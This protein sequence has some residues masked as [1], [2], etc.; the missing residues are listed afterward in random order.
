MD[1]SILDQFKRMAGELNITDF[2]DGPT[3]SDGENASD[4]GSEP[5]EE[6][7]ESSGR[8]SPDEL[9]GM[10]D[11][12]DNELPEE[13]RQLIMSGRMEMER[14]SHRFD[15]M[16]VL[17]RR[18]QLSEDDIFKR[19]RELEDANEDDSSDKPEKS[20]DKPSEKAEETEDTKVETGEPDEPTGRINMH[21]LMDQII[22]QVIAENGDS[23]EITLEIDRVVE[24]KFKNSNHKEWEEFNRYKHYK[25]YWDA[26]DGID[27]K[28]DGTVKKE[29]PEDASEDDKKNFKDTFH[30]FSFVWPYGQFKS[31]G[32]PYSFYLSELE[33]PPVKLLIWTKNP[34]IM[35][36]VKELETVLPVGLYE[37]TKEGIM[38]MI[39]DNPEFPLW[40]NNTIR[41]REL[42]NM[43]LRKQIILIPK[44][45]PGSS[46]LDDVFI[47]T[48]NPD[49]KSKM[50]IG[51]MFQFFC[52]R[53]EIDWERR[54]QLMNIEIDKIIAKY[55]PF[56]V[57][58]NTRRDYMRFL[59]IEY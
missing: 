51:K 21:S 32:V 49:L 46:D 47:V 22:E 14:P 56:M 5:T 59:Q 9:D 35:E 31:D 23:H 44:S 16:E 42:A 24:I 34:T 58:L 2:T 7:R 43:M 55:N 25:F 54:K 27:L 20:A 8:A 39:L 4:N 36:W 28:Y 15:H 1:E 10:P 57:F 3:E 53:M 6:D 48:I 29:L 13:I 37:E 17:K 38:V 50:H 26:E 40:K 18:R 19:I 33:K 11:F 30:P 45:I 41:D 52:S 12:E